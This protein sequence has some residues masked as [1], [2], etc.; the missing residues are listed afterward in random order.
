MRHG[1]LRHP[2]RPRTPPH[3][4]PISGLRLCDRHTNRAGRDSWRLCNGMLACPVGDRPG[5]ASVRS[6]PL[7]HRTRTLLR[8]RHRGGGSFLVAVPEW[9]HLMTKRIAFGQI[10]I[11][12]V[13]AVVYGKEA[14]DVMHPIHVAASTALGALASVLA[15][16]LPYPRLA[17]AE[18]NKLS[19]LY[20]QNASERISLLMKAFSAQNTTIALETI[21][22][23][24]PLQETGAKLLQSIKLIQKAIESSK[25]NEFGDFRFVSY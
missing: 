25:K 11:V 5:T 3:P 10:V 16:L 17:Y 4:T 8:G 13:G 15:M 12:Y 14:G 21:S 22:Q 20:T 1:G 2:L 6:E 19:R 7:A 9:S 18:V 24:K 23:A